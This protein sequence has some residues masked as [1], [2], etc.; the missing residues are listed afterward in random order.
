MDISIRNFAFPNLEEVA[1]VPICDL[2]IGSEAFDVDLL[3]KPFQY[4][5]EHENAF[6]VLL[7][8]IL[9]NTIVDS[10]GNV[11]EERANPQEQLDYA[12]QLFSDFK[13]KILACVSGNH[14]HRTQKKAGI[15]LSYT[16]ATALNIPLYDRN[17]AMLDVCV[18]SKARS[19]LKRRNYEIVIYHG[20]GGGRLIGTK[21]TSATRI[22][23]MIPDADVYLSGHGHFISSVKDKVIL[24][25]RHNKTLLERERWIITAPAYVEREEYA[26]RNL[27]RLSSPGM[28]IVKLRGNRTKNEIIVEQA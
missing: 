17:I 19:S 7:G 10:V 26:L 8:D 12:I 27:S 13:G 3:K 15:D 2:H 6:I 5:R 20:T 4:V 23:D 24:I 21:V 9:N 22:T 14:E 1:I 25:D 18:G 28:V 16:L 11:Y